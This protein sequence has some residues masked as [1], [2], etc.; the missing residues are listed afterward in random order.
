M[1]ERVFIEDMET[2]KEKLTRL[3]SMGMSISIDDFGKGYSSLIYLKRLPIDNIKID[4]S[5]IRD[6]DND[7]E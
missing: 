7:P 5:F 2:V 4:I 1:T 6:I 3:K